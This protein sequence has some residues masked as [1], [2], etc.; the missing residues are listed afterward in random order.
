VINTSQLTNNAT[1]SINNTIGSPTLTVPGNGNTC[2]TLSLG[3]TLTGN[4]NYTLTVSGITDCNGNA[5]ATPTVSFNYFVAVTPNFKDIVINEIY[6]DPSPIINL[7]TTE[8]IELYN[9]SSNS[10]NLNGLKVADTYTGTGAT[11]GNYTLAPNSYVI[12]CPIADTAQFTAL[13]YMNKLGVSSFPSLNNTGDNLYLKNASS[14]V[15]DSVNY[16]DTW[17]QDA[18]KKNGGYTLEQINPNQNVACSQANNWIASNDVDGGTPGFVNSVYSITSDVIGPSLLSLTIVDS[19]HITVCF[20]DVIGVSQLTN[21]ANY[22]INNSIGSPTMAVSGS[23]NM[24]ATLSLATNLINNTSYILTVSAITDCNANSISTPTINFTYV[25]FGIPNFKDIVI[26]E[27]YA[28]PSPLVNL[29]NAE[30]VELYNKSSNPYNLSGLKLTDGSSI[31]TFGNYTLIPNS[32][33]IICPVAD[34]AQFTALGYTNKLG[35]SSFPSL[36][37]TGDNLY[38]K[39]AANVFIDSVNYSDTWYKDAIKKDGGYT[40]EQIN[41]N[42]SAAC[43][44]ANNWIGSVDADGGTPGFINSVYSITP[45]LTG[46][47]IMIVNVIDSTH[48]SVC[49]DD[50]ISSAQLNT[51][52]NYTISSSIGSPSFAI[53]SSGNTCVVLSLNNKLINATNYTITIIGLTDCNG[54]QINSNT[55]LF[56]YYKHKAYDV[57]INELMPDPDPAINLPTEE[58]VELKN[59]TAFT[60]NLKNWSFSSTTSTKKLPNITIKPDSFIVLTGTGNANAFDNYGIVAYEVTSFPALT[61]SGGTLTLR[62][63]NGVVINSVTYAS[64]WYNDANKQ[65]GGWSMEQIDPNNPCAGQNN[66]H[67]SYDVNGGTPGRRNSVLASN[68]DNSAPQLE[69]IAVVNADTIILFFTEPLDSISLTNP[70]IYSFDNGLTQPTY[71][72]P[73]APNYKKVKLKLSSSMQAGIVYN[74]TVLDGIKD[75]VGN[76]ISSGSSAPFALPQAPLPN[77]VVI[78]EILFDPNTGGVDFVELYNRSNKTINLKDLRI[79]SMDTLTGNLTSTEDITTEGYL[80]FPETY[81]VISESAATIKQQYFTPNP[82]GFLDIPTLPS[83]N[84]TDD[85]VTLSDANAVVIDNFKYTSKMH[86]PLLVSTKG[87]SLERIDF[88]RPTNDRTNWNSAAEAVGFATPAYRN[89]QYLQA[90]GGSGVSVSNPLFSPDNDGYNDVLNISY[91]LDEPGKAANVYIYDS[92]GR[93][94]RYLIRNEQLALDGTLSWNGINDDNEKAP[95]GIYVIYVELFN[96]SGKVN[97]YKL[98]CT[99]AGKL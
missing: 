49:F 17:Y 32:Y 19:L 99:L 23:G 4:A 39:T 88:N 75:C 56:S 45:D 6:A 93:Q 22:S 80:L 96:L 64:S 72:L 40:L 7:T 34:T 66:W 20:N 61:N 84:T 90:D 68:P 98:S 51:A 87:V 81:L 11:L 65:D 63:S 91:K 53:A 95:I 13:G 8:F 2:A 48:I 86:F 67:A 59:R 16:S 83:M 70:A 85:V 60:I 62:D 89:S 46:P 52:S 24:C 42:Q 38:L 94:V 50:V 18:V 9:N 78:N 12:I 77:D 73:L 82:K 54:N 92:R 36:N 10:F 55:G 97:K 28:D 58:Y 76:S 26:N 69:R 57:V 44:Q 27:I 3:T 30:F 35:V 1:Y 29:T 31:A 5:M 43:S 15:L 41:P 47:K 33:V 74:C 71:I 14:V 79:G 37:N 25:V 21:A